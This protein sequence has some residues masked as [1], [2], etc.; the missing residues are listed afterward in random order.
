MKNV[1]KIFV[2]GGGLWWLLCLSILFSC[3][4]DQSPVIN[5]YITPSSLHL[6]KEVN[7]VIRFE[8]LA[9]ANYKVKKFKFSYQRKN[10]LEQV[11]LDSLLEV[12]IKTFTYTYEFIIPSSWQGEEIRYYFTVID[13]DGNTE[14]A[15]RVVYV[16]AV[17]QAPVLLTEYTGNVIYSKYS[18][19][20][21]AYD[22]ETGE[23]NFSEFAPPA[24]RDIQDY[25]TI[26]SDSILYRAFISG[27]GAMFVR[28]NNF[29]YANAT[30][31][32]ANDAYNAGVKYAIISN[33]QNGD[34][35]LTKTSSGTIAVIK[36]TQVVD[37]AGVEYD[38]IEFNV[39][40]PTP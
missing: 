13:A 6:Y 33:I 32:S 4:K 14:K 28:F 2:A 18:S 31:V 12:P 7:E 8:V 19:S 17:N 27:T 20:P 40:K 25:D 23:V 37:V 9:E 38:R 3:K 35:I 26:P 39:K 24:E 34:I 30:D 1:R 36:I 15:T 16:K 21:D 22:I 10:A 5:I 11:I 29:D